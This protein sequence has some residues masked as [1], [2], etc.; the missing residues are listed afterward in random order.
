MKSMGTE[1]KIQVNLTCWDTTS[2]QT[3]NGFSNHS[4]NAFKDIVFLSTGR[5]INRCF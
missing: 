3:M 5:S 4:W 1:I 2:S